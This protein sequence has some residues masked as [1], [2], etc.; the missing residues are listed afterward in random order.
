MTRSGLFLLLAVAITAMLVPDL[1]TANE[2][3]P[4]IKFIGTKQEAR[5]RKVAVVIDQ[6]HGNVELPAAGNPKKTFLVK[7]VAESAKARVYSMVKLYAGPEESKSYAFLLVVPTSVSPFL[8]IISFAED[9]D[10]V[11]LLQQVGAGTPHYPVLMVHPKTKKQIPS[12]LV[13]KGF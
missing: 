1:A 12:L 8:N 7:F 3:V 6:A 10:V 5:G 11:A 4:A 2:P 9:P 13:P